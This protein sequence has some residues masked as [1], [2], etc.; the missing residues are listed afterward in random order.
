[1]VIRKTNDGLNE[2]NKR[3][4]VFRGRYY[5]ARQSIVEEINSRPYDSKIRAVIVLALEILDTQV[6]SGKNNQI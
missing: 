6:E 1:M 5:T 3:L 2:T 4:S